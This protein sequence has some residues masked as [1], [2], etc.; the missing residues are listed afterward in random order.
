MSEKDD[1]HGNLANIVQKLLKHEPEEDK[2][3]EVK[4]LYLRPKN[5]EMLAETRVNLAI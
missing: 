5:C 3:K 2:L 4:K 1:I